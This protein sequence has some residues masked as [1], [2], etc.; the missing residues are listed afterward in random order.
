MPAS[1]LLAEDQTLVV[2]SR[3]F[4]GILV[5]VFPFFLCFGGFSPHPVLFSSTPSFLL[6]LSTEEKAVIRPQD[7]ENREASGFSP[8]SLNSWGNNGSC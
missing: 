6:F 3:K 2:S 4:R 7:K 1:K 8:M 5:S